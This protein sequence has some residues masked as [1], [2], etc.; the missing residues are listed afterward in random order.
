MRRENID[1]QATVGDIESISAELARR[2]FLEFILYTKPDFVVNWHHEFIARKMQDF[3]DGKIK[4][5]MVFLPTQVGKSEMA[6]RRLPAYLLGKYPNK[7]IGVISNADTKAKAFNLNVQKIIDSNEYKKCFPDTKLATGKDKCKRTENV[8]DIVGKNG[9]MESYGVSG[10]AAGSSFDFLILDDTI[11]NLQD[12]VSIAIQKRNNNAWDAVLKL[13]LDNNSQII[14]V[15]TRWAEDDLVGY[16]L[17]SREFDFEVIVFPALKVDD[18]NPDDPRE[19]GEALWPEKHSRERYEAQ[20]LANPVVFETVQQQNPGVPT[21]ILVYP[22]PWKQIEEMPDYSKFYGMD[23]GFS[24]SPDCLVECM[25]NGNMAYL[26]ELFYETGKYISEQDDNSGTDALANKIKSV[27][28]AKGPIYCDSAHPRTIADLQARG[29]NAL[30][31]VKGPGS[32]GAGILFL[33]GLSIHLTENSTDAWLEKKKYQYPTG[34]DNKPIPGADPI[35]AFDHFMDAAR[36]GLYSYSILGG[37]TIF[38]S[39][40]DFY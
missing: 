31:C 19:I 16:I 20:K 37:I 9:G 36:Y 25:I 40:G 22:K 23:F 2:D 26:R 21:E 7:R 32:L 38:E 4:N 5:L 17:K 39:K 1:Y 15:N 29:I 10:P 28:A 33:Q 27:G 12:A 35:K 6:T 24:T 18:N 11:K 30:P 13:R 3:V 14:I 8:F 34:P